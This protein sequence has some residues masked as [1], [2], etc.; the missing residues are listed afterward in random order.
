[1]SV[2]FE[3]SSSVYQSP[4]FFLREA[5]Q[6]RGIPNHL[7]ESLELLPGDWSP[8][9]LI[10]HGERSNI[11]QEG[12]D[13][14]R[15]TEEGRRASC[16]LGSILGKRQPGKLICSPVERCVETLEKICEGASWDNHI[17]KEQFFS[18]SGPFIT[19]LQAAVKEYQRIGGPALFNLQIT[20]KS[21]PPGMRSTAEGV[22]DFLKRIL[23]LQQEAGKIHIVVTHDAVITVVMGFLLQREFND[24]NW[25][26]FL[27]GA[28]FWDDR[29]HLHILWEGKKYALEWAHLFERMPYFSK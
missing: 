26:H 4:F 23:S 9:L 1:M 21:P 14:V 25:P 18:P 17:E 5:Y 12:P 28:L 2:N 19:D 16:L 29:V 11:P 20:Q 10:R 22:A 6:G 27:A 7:L 15:L 24:E 8:V 13:T 3:F